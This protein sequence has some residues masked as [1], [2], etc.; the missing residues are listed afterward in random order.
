MLKPTSQFFRQIIYFVLT[1]I[2]VGQLDIFLF[3]TKQKN[4]KP[5]PAVIKKKNR[6]SFLF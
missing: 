6:I 3:Q 1:D 4:R 2:N 5:E